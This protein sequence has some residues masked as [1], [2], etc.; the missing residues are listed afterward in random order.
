MA[1][2]DIIGEP[3]D[4]YVGGQITARQKVYGSINR[5]TNEISYLNS[6][7][8]W[9]KLTSGVKVMDS[10]RLTDI[11]VSGNGLTGFS[12]LNS[13]MVLFGGTYNSY[14]K[15]EFKGIA[16]G[17][18]TLNTSAYGF[19]GL[20]QG[21]RPMPGITS[22][23][24]KFR[25]RGAI[26]EGTVNIKVWNRKQLE[27]VDL[28]YLRLG[29]PMLLEW[30]HSIIV[31]NNGVINSNPN[32]SISPKFYSG[33]Y[34]TD[35]AILDDLEDLR[36]KSS[37][38]YDGMYGRVQ[39]FSFSYN[40]DGSYD[41]E[42]KLISIGAVIESLKANVLLDTN[43]S[44]NKKEEKKDDNNTEPE[45]NAEWIIASRY[46]HEIGKYFF[47]AYSTIGDTNSWSYNSSQFE[48]SNF[49]FTATLAT[50]LAS[51]I[52][53]DTYILTPDKQYLKLTTES[54]TDLFFIR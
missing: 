18:T 39:N 32:Y 8:G 5:S 45:T 2:G 36:N 46:S 22:A 41:I 15:T 28:I 17:D 4:E 25:N 10:K 14:E 35:K 53:G 54:T 9:I 52:A 6:K 26:R 29:F 30:G 33:T 24:T 50:T 23:E 31:E 21:Y 47:D 7:T 20:E 19:G 40:K 43:T 48:G 44:S 12:G 3:F 51:W 11:Q 27:M 49:Q 13:R 38:N 16:S 42:L 37:G 1:Q 34:K